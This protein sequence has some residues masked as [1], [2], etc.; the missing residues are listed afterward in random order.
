[1][2][3][4]GGWRRWREGDGCAGGE[5]NGRERIHGA[6]RGSPP[7]DQDL[8]NGDLAP[9]NLQL[10]FGTMAEGI[11]PDKQVFDF[12]ANPIIGAEKKREVLDDIC[13]SSVLLPHITNFFNILVE[14]KRVDA[15]KDIV[16]EFEKVYNEI[17]D[18]EL[19]LVGSVVKLESEHLAQ[20]VKQVQKLTGV[21]N[22]RIETEIDTSLIAGFTIRYGNG[23]SKLI[24]MSV[25]K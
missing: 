13:K 19:A 5:G 9:T 14:A 8:E 24:D 22:V 1:M 21:K 15:I 23:G 18:T 6:S 2:V 20:I 17:T 25:K 12:F 4:S 10:R 16:K 3:E 11:T 7:M